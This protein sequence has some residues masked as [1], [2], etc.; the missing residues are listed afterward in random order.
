MVDGEMH[1]L[2]YC[3]GKERAGILLRI[4]LLTECM[5]RWEGEEPFLLSL[6]LMQ[7]FSFLCLPFDA[8]PRADLLTHRLS[9]SLSLCFQEP[10][11]GLPAAA[12]ASPRAGGLAVP[13]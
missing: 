2:E 3:I 7:F 13:M 1:V 11:R 4:V 5:G 9:L 10:L 12:A 8:L 6:M